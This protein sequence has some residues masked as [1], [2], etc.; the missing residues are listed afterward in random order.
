MMGSPKTEEGRDNDETQ[1]S[2]T[3][4]TGF[5]MMETQVTQT[6]WVAIMGKN[7][8][9]FIEEEGEKLP[10]EHVSWGACK[11]F[12][13]KCTELG[14]PIELPTEAQWEYACRAGS[15]TA[16]FWGKSLKGDK[17]NCN[18]NYPCGTS[19]KGIRVG[20]P[21][22][23]GR[24]DPNEWGLYD[25]HGNVWE[26]CEDKYGKYSSEENVTDPIGAS[27]GFY[28][29]IRGGS[30]NKG[31]KRCR[32][33]ARGYESKGSHNYELGFRCVCLINNSG[34]KQLEIDEKKTR[35]L[36]GEKEVRRPTKAIPVKS[37]PGC[38]KV[39]AKSSSKAAPAAKKTA[40]KKTCA[41]KAVANSRSQTTTPSNEKSL[42]GRITNG[43]KDYLSFG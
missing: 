21:T 1:H 23:V 3:L 22:T 26:W 13:L 27:S 5:W 32:S 9:Y 19:S 7:P 17:A 16:Y 39:V 38:K 24:Y 31:A 42:L 40:V 29:V 4:T 15:T 36:S 37:K 10:V 35:E 41:K 6:Q 30:W 33:A 25:M 28:R 11:K 2:V 14:L 34:E 8:S 43:I 18:G 12:C 20:T